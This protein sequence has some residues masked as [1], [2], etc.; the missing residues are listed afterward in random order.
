MKK[1]LF[2]AILGLVTS[3]SL[4]AQNGTIRGKIVDDSNGE[5]LIGVNVV[6]AGTT[7]GTST[8]LDGAFSLTAPVGTHKVNCS[9]ISYSMLTV[10]DVVVKTG[11]VTNLGELRLKSDAIMTETVVIEARRSRNNETAM[12]TMQKKSA[13]VMDGISSQTFKKVGDGDAGKAIKRVTGVSVEGGKYVY[14]RGL[15][16]RY[17]KTT[18]NGMEVP[19]LD[20]DRNAL[21]LDIFPTNLIDNITVYKTFTPELVGDFT[22]GS[23]DIIT[24]DFP[25]ERSYNL[26]V[27]LDYNPAMHLRSDYLTY[28]GSSLDAFGLGSADRDVPFNRNIDLDVQT[29]FLE[30]ERASDLTRRF[31]RTMG[32]G[33]VTSLLNSSIGFSL[34]NQFN[35]EKYTKGIIASFNYSNSY[36]FYENAIFS[37][38][39]T[40]ADTLETE[41]LLRNKDSGRVAIND[42][43]WSGFVSGSIKSK[44]SSLSLV[45][46][47]LQNG[48]KQSSL[49]NGEQ[50]GLLDQ[51]AIVQKH[52]LY[53]NQ[54]SISNALVDFKHSVPYNNM[55]IRYRFS[56]TLALNKEPDFRQTKYEID[57]NGIFISGGGIPLVQR[58][59]R[60]LEEVGYANRLDLKMDVNPSF[61][62]EKSILKVGAAY[63]YKNRNF[64]V[65]T[66]RFRE[67]QARA[68]NSLDPDDI[69]DPE[70]IFDPVTNQGGVNA[71]GFE[72]PNNI[73]ESN[74]NYSAA[75]FMLESPL[76]PVLKAI[77]G[78][79]YE[80][81]IINYTGQRQVVLDSAEDIFDNREVLN[82]SNFLPS[83]GLVYN[84]AEDV[85]LRANYSKTVARPSFKEKSLSEIIDALTGRVFIGN[86]DLKQTEIDNYDIRLE[87]FYPRGQLVSISAFYKRF[88]NPIEVVAFD[89]TTGPNQFTPRNS[90]TALVYG[91]ELDA[92]KNLAFLKDD[93]KNWYVGFNFTYVISRI[94][95]R[96]IITPG[97]DGVLG[98]ADDIS[99]FDERYLNKR[100]G[101]NVDEFRELQG[102]SPYVVNAFVNYENDSLGF[103]ANLS[104]NVQGRSLA[105]VGIARSPNVWNA[106][107]H[108]LTFKAS[109]SIGKSRSSTISFSVDNILNDKR[110]QLYD[111]YRA[112]DRIFTQLAP[113]RTFSIGYGYKF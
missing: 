89:Q 44:R 50:S 17:T 104:Y 85:N 46:M 64:D 9:Y 45:L 52:V 25:E 58:V 91:G 16:D 99:E 82:E 78:V 47:H 51:S 29:V 98:T 111:S 90:S 87:K 48:Q 14:V 70:N 113:N 77:Y 106:P 55:E 21:Q 3:F 2:Y 102:Q 73:Y 93:L 96:D 56:P 31:D 63:T 27:S 57:E 79:R 18:L 5:T 100:A 108:N 26:A 49:L 59:Y 19:G 8:D 66:Y 11:E 109:K 30:P 71:F 61:M 65:L 28:D 10:N 101:E 33:E 103:T 69:L 24:K 6:I 23:V 84:L 7:I 76:S 62:E 80:N 60:D 68:D 105:I 94:D 43:F 112:E 72:Q 36:E 74:S 4:Y 67:Q 110:E 54:R 53:Y 83:L 86:I 92:R 42:V 1:K 20:P 107:F 32:S 81:F 95:R 39:I 35:G 13:N 22:G 75:Y 40:P 37:E 97:N 34:G 88:V 12:A 15:G 38:Y 41:L